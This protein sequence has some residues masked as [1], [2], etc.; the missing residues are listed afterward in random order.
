MIVMSI[1]DFAVFLEVWVYWQTFSPSS[2]VKLDEIL[3]FLISH[4]IASAACVFLAKSLY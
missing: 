4:V 3:A 1:H 2:Y